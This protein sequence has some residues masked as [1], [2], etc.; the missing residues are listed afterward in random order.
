[1]QTEEIEIAEL[2][3]LENSSPYIDY[4]VDGV[5]LYGVNG[6]RRQSSLMRL[7]PASIHPQTVIMQ[8]D[9][10]SPIFVKG[11]VLTINSDV[12][13]EPGDYMLVRFGHLLLIRRYTDR[14]DNTDFIP[15]NPAYPEI[16]DDRS[17][18]PWGVVSEVRHVDGTV[19]TFDLSTHRKI[20]EF[21]MW[22]E[23]NVV[24]PSA[25]SIMAVPSHN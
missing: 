15:E 22:V 24:A 5:S 2:N 20:N 25:S 11:D 14:G 8:D 7:A 4:V 21:A 9:S 3:S 1:M 13:E 23:R 19:E 12:F 6:W 10:M 16:L 18:D 17:A